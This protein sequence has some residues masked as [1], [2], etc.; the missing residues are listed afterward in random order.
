VD[1]ILKDV[2][3]HGK[4][5]HYFSAAVKKEVIS[6]ESISNCDKA[7]HITASLKARHCQYSDTACPEHTSVLRYAYIE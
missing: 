3:L 1:Y 5:K 7:G 4:H 6:L 2:R